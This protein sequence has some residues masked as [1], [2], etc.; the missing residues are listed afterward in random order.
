MAVAKK[1]A[2]FSHFVLYTRQLPLHSPASLHNENVVD[3]KVPVH[4]LQLLKCAKFNCMSV[5]PCLLYSYK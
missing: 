3:T 2:K 4:E 1:K 5:E